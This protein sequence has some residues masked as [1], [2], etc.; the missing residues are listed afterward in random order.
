[1]SDHKSKLSEEL[2]PLEKAL[3]T[4]FGSVYSELTDLVS[5]QL[6]SLKVIERLNT[7][8]GLITSF[9]SDE[10]LC[11]SNPKESMNALLVVEIDGLD[12]DERGLPWLFIKDGRLDNLDM[13]CGADTS[14]IDFSSSSLGFEIPPFEPIPYIDMC[15]QPS[16][17][18]MFARLKGM[19]GLR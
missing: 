15:D 1:M 5:D 6:P 14:Q 13:G 11:S 2:T 10:E 17:K 9:T 12:I 16:S 7:G 8:G 4:E 18:S 19:I 3:L